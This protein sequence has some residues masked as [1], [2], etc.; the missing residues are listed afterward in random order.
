[1]RNYTPT[2]AELGAIVLLDRM[3][4]STVNEKGYKEL[5]PKVGL[6]YGDGMYL[7]RYQRTLDKL[8]IMGYAASNLV[9][10]V[11]GILRGHGRDTMGF[12][13]KATY[14]EINGVAT[15]IEKDPITD[16]GKKSLKGLMYLDHDPNTN[17][18]TTIDQVS[19]EVEQNGLLCEVFR[20]GTVL[21]EYTLADVRARVEQYICHSLFHRLPLMYVNVY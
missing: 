9:I 13:I 4:G 3:F 7:E 19:H 14:V 6:I 21:I 17:N 20:D 16:P 8:R 10:G 18:W 15:E 11:G 2:P 12:A 5:N 1:M